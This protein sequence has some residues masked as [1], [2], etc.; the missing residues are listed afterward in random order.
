MDTRNRIV[1]LQHPGEVKRC[2][3]TGRMLQLGLAP[4]K[5]LLYRGKLFPNAKADDTLHEILND[6]KRTLL[7]YPT[8]D[9]VPIDEIDINEGPFN[10]VLLDGTWPQ[11]KAIYSRSTALHSLRQ[12]KLVGGGTSHYVIRTQPAEGCLS[13]LETAAEA[14]SCLER[15]PTI[16]AKLVR[17]L[18]ELCRFQLDNGAVHHQSKEF[19]IRTR[20]YPKQIGRRLTKLLKQNEK[21][22]IS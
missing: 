22:K 4:D 5:C 14:L 1:M 3:Q 6:K 12:V 2:L 8:P 10:I 13:T 7:L 19:L 21:I 18:I 9:A 15:D 20:T 17:P 16:K 11:A